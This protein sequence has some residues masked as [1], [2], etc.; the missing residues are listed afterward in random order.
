[1]EESS[2]T[3]QQEI[4]GMPVP[5]F[6]DMHISACTDSCIIGRC[7]IAVCEQTNEAQSEWEPRVVAATRRSSVS[8][9]S[10]TDSTSH[11]TLASLQRSLYMLEYKHGWT[12]EG[13]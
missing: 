5:W 8:D 12:Y 3:N 13:N 10:T 6:Y 11:E 1:M 4:N 2:L 7:E 9:F